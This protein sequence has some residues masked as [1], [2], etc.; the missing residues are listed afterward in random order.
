MENLV[1]TALAGLVVTGSLLAVSPASAAEKHAH[2]EGELKLAIEGNKVVIEL[3]APGSDIVGFEHKPSLDADRKAVAAAA[4]M[5]KDGGALFAFPDKARCKMQ[6]ADVHSEM[7]HDDKHKHGDGD[8]AE[9]EVHYSFS[10]AT[11]SALTHVDVGY[12]KAFPRAHELEVQMI[13]Q[14]GQG[15]A[16]LTASSSRLTF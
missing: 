8:H 7:L 10:C 16:E 5:L 15:A 9:F 11:P 12:F 6:E 14:K 2:G 1:R 3:T 13:T 4:A